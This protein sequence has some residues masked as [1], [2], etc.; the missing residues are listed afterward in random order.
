MGG[1]SISFQSLFFI[2]QA[3]GV[4]VLLAA[5]F[6]GIVLITKKK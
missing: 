4:F 5:L 6:V 2:L 1:G 3:I